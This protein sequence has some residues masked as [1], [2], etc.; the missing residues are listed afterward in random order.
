MHHNKKIKYSELEQ[1]DYI[2]DRYNYIDKKE[3]DKTLSKLNKK[4]P[5][6]FKPISLNEINLPD[7]NCFLYSYKLILTGILISGEKVCVILNNIKPWFDVKINNKEKQINLVCEKLIQ[8]IKT[9]LNQITLP[10]ERKTPLE[11]EFDS[12]EILQG[13]PL[14]WFQEHKNYYIR[15]KFNKTKY[16][17]MIIK[18][19]RENNYETANDDLSSFYKVVGRSYGLSFSSWSILK[20]YDVFNKKGYPSY[21]KTKILTF[22]LSYKYY[23]PINDHILKNNFKEDTNKNISITKDN[24]LLFSWDVETYSPDK[25]VPMP[26]DDDHK[27]FMIGISIHKINNKNP[28]LRICIVDVPSDLDKDFLLIE[29]KNEKEILFSFS[30]ILSKFQPDYFVG[31]N[32]SMYDNKWIMERGNKYDGYIEKFISKVS[33][34]NENKIF[35][36]GDKKN[37]TLLN[38]IKWVYKK[39]DIKIES[40]RHFNGTFIFINGM[41]DIDVR[42]LFMKLYS[43]HEKSSLNYYLKLLGFELKDDLSIYNLFKWYEQAVCLKNKTITDDN[44][45]EKLKKSKSRMRKIGHYCCVDSTRTAELLIKSNIL[46]DSC[47]VSNLSFVTIFD[48]LYRANSSKVRNLI[49]YEATKRNYF[50]SNII[51]NNNHVDGKYTGG[52]VMEPKYG[53]K[54]SKLSIEERIKLGHKQLENINKIKNKNPSIAS[55]FINNDHIEWVNIDNIKKKYF[56]NIVNKHG[57]YLSDEEIHKIE[58]IE[59]MT[60]PNCFKLFLKEK[61]YYP[62]TG[63]DFKSLYP[64]LIMTYNF[65]PEFMIKNKKQKISLEKKGYPIHSPIKFSFNHNGNI[66]KYVEGWVIKHNNDFHKKINNFHFGIY[67]YILKKLYDKRSEMKKTKKKLEN[68]LEQLRN[69]SNNQNQ[70]NDIIHKYN[71][72]NSKQKALKIFMNCFYGECGSQISPLYIPQIAGGITMFGQKHITDAINIVKKISC[73][74]YY[75]DSVTNDTP[76]LI[77]KNN[78]INIVNIDELFHFSKNEYQINYDQN[79]LIVKDICYPSSNIYVYSH[80]SW[81]KITKIIRH[82]YNKKITRISTSHGIVDVTDDHSLLTKKL[83]KITPEKCKINKTKLFHNYIQYKKNDINN[84]TIDFFTNQLLLFE[85]NVNQYFLKEYLL[86]FIYGIFFNNG[87]ICISNKKLY[88]SLKFR[89]NYKKYDLIVTILNLLY[90]DQKIYFHLN[91]NIITL[92]D[93]NQTFCEKYAKSFYNSKYKKII[94]Q[95]IFNGSDDNKLYFLLG[96]LYNSDYLITKTIIFYEKITC[97]HFYFLLKIFNINMCLDFYDEIYEIKLFH[98]GVVDDLIKKKNIISTN[99]NNYVFDLETENHTFQAGIGELIVHNTDSIYLSIPQKNF[100]ILD[101]SYYSNKIN[102]LTYWNNLI[103]ITLKHMENIKN[104]VNISF[105]KE[106]GCDFLE[107]AYEEI[108]FPCFFLT[109]KKY[110]GHEHVNFPNFKNPHLFKR[111]LDIVRRGISPFLKKI[112][113]DVIETSLSIHNIHSLTEIIL[114]KIDSIYDKKWNF[115]DFIKTDTYKPK[116][117]NI[118]VN[119]FVKNTYENHKIKIKPCERFEYVIVKKN[120]IYYSVSGKKNYLKISDKMELISVAKN[121]KYLLDIDYYMKSVNKQLAR[122]ISFYNTFKISDNNDTNLKYALNFLD[123]YCTQYYTKYI[124]EGPVRKKTYKYINNTIKKKISKNKFTT[125]FLSNNIQSEKMLVNKIIEKIEKSSKSK[126]KGKGKLYVDNILENLSLSKKKHKIIHLQKKFYFSKNNHKNNTLF[127]KATYIKNHNVKK[128]HDHLSNIMHD[129][130]HFYKSKNLAIE[131]IICNLNFNNSSFDFIKNQIENNKQLDKLFP[132]TFRTLT[133]QIK[134]NCEKLEKI[135]DHYWVIYFIV[136]YLKLQNNHIPNITL[137]DK[138]HIE[139]SSNNI[140]KNTMLE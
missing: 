120:P 132:S 53:F 72:I 106:T 84:Y 15:L 62:I 92:S 99:Y 43:T 69:I 73:N 11:N 45:I 100:N 116:K 86:C 47:N 136:E 26:N 133:E 68:I 77:K 114:N 63:L 37:N 104:T 64:S 103:N 139:Y 52:F 30:H 85:K 111:G 65:S 107:M 110:Y 67:P 119:D 79:T 42:V 74:V 134:I 138:I 9:F 115:D 101:I 57:H 61:T 70:L 12:Y 13:K 60:F 28:L 87:L 51:S 16:R 2:F 19:L 27:L 22:K 40:T 35:Y 18:Y 54:T 122:L 102:K 32:N 41:I 93:D 24:S 34:F 128:I 97:S 49:L 98:N 20:N 17:N 39:I 5:I 131:N 10:Y 14:K 135:Y 55:K 66:V 36:N 75:G 21:N 31:F 113:T 4:K 56:E 123:E 109:K 50:S 105:K 59:N 23:S 96:V 3:Y 118:K 130:F 1:Y 8:K 46:T 89:D 140:F 58:Q 76:I 44:I 88:W 108:L 48:S 126:N 7:D 124:D 90:N 71:Y 83:H 95:F 127:Y 6:Y 121:K 78:N 137:E 125:L 25:S 91:N 112:Y 129:F 33:I 94:P 82:K 80:N 29:C 81:T 117:K 38:L